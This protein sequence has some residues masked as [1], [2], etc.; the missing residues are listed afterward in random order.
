MAIYDGDKTFLDWASDVGG[1]GQRMRRVLTEMSEQKVDWDGFADGRTNTQIAI[2]LGRT[3]GSG[4]AQAG[5]ASSVTLAAGDTQPDD[6][7]NGMTIQIMSGTGA[8]QE[9]TVTDYVESTKVASAT[10][11]PAPDAT[12]VY[13]IQKDIDVMV[14]AINNGNKIKRIAFGEIA[15]TPSKDLMVEIRRFT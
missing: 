13:A 1:Y 6:F 2:D 3:A 8:G 7:Y 5:S 11:S 14:V 15:Q 4:T 9:V 12:S 10:F